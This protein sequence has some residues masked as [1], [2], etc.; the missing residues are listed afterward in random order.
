MVFKRLLVYKINYL[1]NFK[2]YP[3]TYTFL[4]FYILLHIKFDP[5]ARYM[6]YWHNICKMEGREI[7]RVNIQK[8]VDR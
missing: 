4:T 3:Y 6:N 7:Q 1:S 2:F 5:K 8:Y